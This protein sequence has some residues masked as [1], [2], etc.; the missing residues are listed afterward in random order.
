M[1]QTKTERQTDPKESLKREIRFWLK[2][3]DNYEFLKAV[4]ALVRNEG[5]I[6]RVVTYDSLH[7]ELKK[8]LEEGEA[9][10]AAGR[11]VSH[12]E[13]FKEINEWLENS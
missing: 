4:R 2:R 12:E 9:D 1:D 13:V 7:P 10:I 5:M 6:K 11:V 8:A 3:V